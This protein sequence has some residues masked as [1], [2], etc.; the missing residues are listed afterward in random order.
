M[1]HEPDHGPAPPAGGFWS[2]AKRFLTKGST[3]V[4]LV[5]VAVLAG[6]VC[7]VYEN[8]GTVSKL[9]QQLLLKNGQGVGAKT[10]AVRRSLSGT[11]PVPP[12]ASKHFL[13]C[14][15]W[16]FLERSLQVA[17]SSALST[18]GTESR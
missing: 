17:F 4:L 18:S 15:P 12:K 9:R 10:R 8:P 2:G 7:V 13:A 6:T 16:H 14:C 3:G 11:D 1:E 5:G